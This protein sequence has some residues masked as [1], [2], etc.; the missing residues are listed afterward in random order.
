[1]KPFDPPQILGGEFFKFSEVSLVRQRSVA[2]T[3]GAN[4][5]K[6]D[7][8]QARKGVLKLLLESF[9]LITVKTQTGAVE[10]FFEQYWVILTSGLQI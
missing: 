9:A 6:R 4:P 5:A 10:R 2:D 8:R 1:L 7:R 3:K